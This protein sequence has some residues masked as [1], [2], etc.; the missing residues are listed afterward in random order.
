MLLHI[1]Y[2]LAV[3]VLIPESLSHARQLDARRRHQDEIEARA[4]EELEADEQAKE[5]GHVYVV[6]TQVKRALLR[7]WAFL[8]PLALLL[9]KKGE[10]SVEDLP[11]LKSRAPPRTGW[12]WSLATIALGQAFY[13]IVVVRLPPSFRPTAFSL[14]KCPMQSLTPPKLRELL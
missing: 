6:F 5:D 14:T 11:I 2:L 13:I 10:V 9:P 3:V 12:E 8:R 4:A 1:L 7:P